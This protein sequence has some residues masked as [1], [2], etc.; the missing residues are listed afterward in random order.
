MAIGALLSALLSG[1]KARREQPRPPSPAEERV[2]LW[3]DRQDGSLRVEIDG[4]E[5]RSAGEID[6]R[7]RGRLEA[8]AGE[9]R[10]WLEGESGRSATGEAVPAPPEATRPGSLPGRSAPPAPELPQVPGS[11]LRAAARPAAEAPAGSIAAQIDAILQARL[12]NT[13]LAGRG[14]RLKELPE[15]GMVVMVG[16]EKYLEVAEIPE[17]EVRAAIRAAVAEWEGRAPA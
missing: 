3:R 6:S 8:L 13:P 12:E 4:E 2:Q 5:R 1:L 15:E 14:I 10:R 7:Q 11:A 16:L 17:E 9:L